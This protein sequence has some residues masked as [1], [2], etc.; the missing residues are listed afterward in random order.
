MSEDK[1]VDV[2]SQYEELLSEN[3]LK[4]LK[5]IFSE[6]DPMVLMELVIVLVK[7]CN[8]MMMVANE[9]DAI[10]AIKGK[11]EGYRNLALITIVEFARKYHSAEKA[12]ELKK[13]FE[14]EIYRLTK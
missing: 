3:S 7:N 4:N 8:H 6:H 1:K 13:R 2:V 12:D 9:R 11:I 10:I 14:D 5:L